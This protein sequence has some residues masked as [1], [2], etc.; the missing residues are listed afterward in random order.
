MSRSISYLKF[1]LRLI[2][3]SIRLYVLGPAIFCALVMF[4]GETYSMALSYLFFFLIILATVPF[5]TQGNEKST[6]MYYMFPGKISD[7]VL[8]RFLYLIGVALFIFLINT[9]IATY[10][11]QINRAQEFEIL[12]MIFCG[13]MSLITCFIQYPIYYK[14]GMEKGKAVSLLV[15]LL[16][17]F[18][19]FALPSFL[20]SKDTFILE[21]SLNF[22]INNKLILV[23]IGVLVTALIGYISYLI[24]CKICKAKEI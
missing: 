11:Y 18:F 22:I 8:G 3:E 7:M 16:P 9:S 10:L 19:I 23:V 14:F 13:L 5:S 4:S 12:I 2:K 15:Y 21:S 1:D 6:Q 24:S 17:A 20:L